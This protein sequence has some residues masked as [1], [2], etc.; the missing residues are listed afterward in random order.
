MADISAMKPNGAGGASYNFKDAAARVNINILFGQDQALDTRVTAL[1]NAPSGGGVNIHRIAGPV[2]TNDDLSNPVN[3]VVYW[4][5]ENRAWGYDYDDTGFHYVPLTS[6]MP[7]YPN[8]SA[9][10]VAAGDILINFNE[11]GYGFIKSVLAVMNSATVPSIVLNCI[12]G[13][14]DATSAE[15]TAF[16][17]S[18]ISTYNTYG[19]LL[20]TATGRVGAGVFGYFYEG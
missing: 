20:I 2:I 3:G 1:E 19:T 6:L 8:T 16:F 9:P 5:S 4:D 17:N 12:N 13:N 15:K 14:P 7:Q 10:S 11:D 18:L